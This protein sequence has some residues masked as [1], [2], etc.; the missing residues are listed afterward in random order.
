MIVSNPEC[1]AD[2]ENHF[3][4]YRTRCVFSAYSIFWLFACFLYKNCEIA[5]LTRDII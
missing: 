4:K 2:Y 1:N 3:L 5:I